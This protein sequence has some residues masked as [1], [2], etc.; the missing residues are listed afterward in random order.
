M[1]NPCRFPSLPLARIAQLVPRSRWMLWSLSWNW[2][3]DVCPLPTV[4]FSKIT[5]VDATKSRALRDNTWLHLACHRT[6]EFDE[7]FK[8]AFLMR[9]EPLSLNSMNT[10]E[11]PRR[12]SALL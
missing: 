6:Q 11:R 7:P 8:S 1:S 2:C 9:D 3:E 5:S 4:S 10:N 12:R